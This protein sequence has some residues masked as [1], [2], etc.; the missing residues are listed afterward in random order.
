MRDAGDG[1]GWAIYDTE[2][3]LVGRVSLPPRFEIYEIQDTLLL[4]RW[5]DDEDV[6]F[7]QLR[8]LTRVRP[9]A[10]PP[11]A[12]PGRPAYDQA[13]ELEKKGRRAG[14]VPAAPDGSIAD[15]IGAA[16]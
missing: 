6:E 7:I 12:G 9:R 16:S 13:A 4:G 10:V 11:P 3:R 2:A 1:S 14:A 8:R 15:A 5:R